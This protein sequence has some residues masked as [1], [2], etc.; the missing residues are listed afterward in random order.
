MQILDAFQP[1][2]RLQSPDKR[3]NIT[4][5]FLFFLIIVIR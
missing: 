5:V 1:L 4:L 3:N 2:N